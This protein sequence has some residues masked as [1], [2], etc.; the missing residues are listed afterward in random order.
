MS[1]LTD[2]RHAVVVYPDAVGPDV[3]GN[4]GVRAPDFENPVPLVGRV[5]GN[6]SVELSVNGQQL[7]TRK[8]FRCVEFPSG[9]FSKLRI[10]GD[11]RL[12][13]LAGDPILHDDSPRT[14][15][16]TVAIVTAEP[17]PAYVPPAPAEGP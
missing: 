17:N 5:Q 4:P 8:T 12:W 13:D 2:A 1:L 9:A 10:D 15:H 11:P 16:Y 14:R 6:A 3:L 7:I